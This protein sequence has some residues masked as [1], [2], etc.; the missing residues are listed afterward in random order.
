MS[1]QPDEV[2]REDSLS[3]IAAGEDQDLFIDDDLGTIFY[4]EGEIGSDSDNSKGDDEK[5]D[6]PESE[7]LAARPS[8]LKTLSSGAEKQPCTDWPA[9]ARKKSWQCEETDKNHRSSMILEM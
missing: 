4:D 5:Q 9:K 6:S 8:A 3:T 1:E 2:E 7:T